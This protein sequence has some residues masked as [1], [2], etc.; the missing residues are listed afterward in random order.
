M[1]MYACMCLHVCVS[2]SMCCALP[3]C[4]CVYTGSHSLLMFCVCVCVCVCVCMCVFF[5]RGGGGVL[6]FLFSLVVVASLF[7]LFFFLLF[8]SLFL[9]SAHPA[10]PSFHP[11]HCTSLSYS[12]THPP[13]FFFYLFSFFSSPL[14]LSFFLIVFPHTPPH[15]TQPSLSFSRK[16]NVTWRKRGLPSDLWNNIPVDLLGW[17][18]TTSDDP[19]KK[20]WPISINLEALQVVWS[21]RTAS[22]PIWT[23]TDPHQDVSMWL[24][25]PVAIAVLLPPPPPKHSLLMTSALKALTLKATCY[26]V[27]HFAHSYRLVGLVVKASTSRAEDPWFKSHLRQIFLSQVI[28]VTKIWH[29]SGYPARCLVL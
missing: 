28:L 24:S 11:S 17:P 20:L 2:V 16:L 8:T 27:V 18:L 5:K 29:S 7:S 14:P 25:L 12:M 6:S 21:L 13:L 19:Q 9:H 22:T 15:C 1:W 4:M 26:W 10:C 23:R 3:V